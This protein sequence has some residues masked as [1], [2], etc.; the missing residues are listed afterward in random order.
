[1]GLV[2]SKQFSAQ[3]CLKQRDALKVRDRIRFG[4]FTSTE[5]KMSSQQSAVCAVSMLPG[6]CAKEYFMA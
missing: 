5:S 4:V 3:Y 6:H 1:M 2:S